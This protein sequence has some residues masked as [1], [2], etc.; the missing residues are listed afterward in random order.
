M[1]EEAVFGPLVIEGGLLPSAL[2]RGGDQ[3]GQSGCEQSGP[4]EKMY[5]RRPR[6]TPWKG[7]AFRGLR[8]D[9]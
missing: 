2:E 6:A 4:R 3:S 8:D 9:A 7:H 1:G 5:A